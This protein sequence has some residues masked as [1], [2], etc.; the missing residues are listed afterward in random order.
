MT[1]LRPGAPRSSS[2]RAGSGSRALRKG[3]SAGVALLAALQAAGL[4][5]IGQ[6]RLKGG[7]SV[8]LIQRGRELFED[9]EYEISIQTLSGALVRPGSTKEQKLET[10]CL[11][12][13]DYITLGNGEEAETFVR[14]L[15]AL[16][17][18]YE[19]PH[20]ESPRFRDFFAAVRTK[21]EGEGRPG[22]MTDQSLTKPVTLRHRSPSEAPRESGMVLT[23]QLEDPDHR[24]ANVKLF[25]RAG[26]TGKFSEETTQFDPA[27]GSVR[28][29][30]PVRAIRPPFVSYYLLAN[31]KNGVPL[32]S[33][34]D[35]DAPL[36]IPVPDAPK[37]WLIPVAVGGAVVGVAGIVLGALALSGALK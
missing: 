11:L 6:P 23:A 1:L 13:K 30:F 2:R 34:G 10:Y 12:A 14:A 36:R 26:S 16:D 18:S 21:W 8:D 33:S 29:I 7:H 19:L 25:F 31:D 3:F 37:K 28:G 15:L 9:Q 24:V 32:A 27:T 17:P 22:L 35:A 4:P 5:A 20:T